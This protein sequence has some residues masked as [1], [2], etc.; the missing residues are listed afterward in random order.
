MSLLDAL[1]RAGVGDVLADETTRAAYSSDASIYRVLPTAVVRPRHTDEIAATLAVCRETGTPL[2]ARGGGTSI[3]GNAIGTG[4]VLDLS[5][6]LGALIDVDPELGTATVQ[7]GTVHATVQRAA[8]AH[9]WRFGP[10]PS[11]H[12]RA[13]VGGMIGNNA[14]G[15]RALAY[16]RMSD[17]IVALTGITG[18]GEEF[19]VASAAHSPRPH[20]SVP[21]EARLADLAAADLETVRTEFGRFGRQASGYAL[22]HLLPERGRDMTRML[23]GSE[24]TLAVVTRATVR[25]V[26]DPPHRRLVVLGFPDFPAAGDAVPAILEL[27]PTACEGI[28]ARIVDVVR[29]RRGPAAVP[30]LPTGSA[31]LFVEISGFDEAEV[32]ERAGR[33]AVPGADR[34]AVD[35]PARAAEL[36]RIREDGA[37]LSSPSPAGLPALAGWEDAAVPPAV[38]GSYLRDFE[39][40][41]VEHRLTGYPY[42]HL[43]DGCLHI[44]LDFPLTGGRGRTAFVEFLDAAAELA[45]GYG[46][47]LSGEH[48]D[49]RARSALLER[50]YSPRAMELMSAVK[51][52]CD[53]GNLLNPG[54][55]V[56]P[57]PLTADL[58]PVAAHPYRRSLALAY[59]EDGGDFSRAVHRCTGVGKC[60]ADNGA[61]NGVMCPSY[62]ATREEQ[63]STRGRARVLQEMLDSTAGQPD[64]RSPAVH[65]ALDLC[66]SCKGCLSDC[67]TG[68]DMASYKAEVLHQSYRRRLRPRSHYALGWLPRWARLASVAPRAANAVLR[69]PPLA[70]ALRW[71]AGVDPRRSLPQFA[72][73]RFGAVFAG[74]RRRPA[75]TPERG[76][77]LLW[78]DTFTE[79]FS[80]EVGVAAVRVLEDAGYEVRIPERTLCC[81]L[82]WI[83]TGQLDAARRILRQTVQA[84]DPVVA[85]GIPIVGLEPSCTA[86]LRHDALELLGEPA[87]A[88]AGAVRTLAEVLT[89]ADYTMPDL[90][91][92]S[93]VAQ[94]HCHQH[95][96][97]GW[98]ADEQ[99][100][101]GAGAQVDRVAGCCGLAGNFGMELGHY[102]TSVAVAEHD[103]LPAVRA[104]AADA[105][106]LADGFSCR[107]QLADLAD[108]I[109]PSGHPVRHLA[110]LIDDALN[111]RP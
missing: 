13:T 27:S 9:G 45:L 88:V 17:N 78:V 39:Q 7:P 64:W 83:S 106:V 107:T 23:V 108:R 29:R 97:M 24:G 63:D 14:C 55:V 21:I 41:L 48:G 109:A 33:V 69:V 94:P 103:L 52:I 68:V 22:E 36:W 67:P 10:D 62:L 12:T 1:R 60:R 93:V 81:G 90:T 51:Q 99:L 28:D 74:R 61:T 2:V 50:M 18:T 26:R 56:D 32:I 44:R 72:V 100:L 102:E 89:E 80:P 6:H 105:T 70:R 92:T 38:I 66:L 43:G 71:T 87:T 91:G 5:R 98:G 20:P 31:W 76:P 54:I 3:A 19:S 75:R 59:V 82:S 53:P 73:R 104:A 35:D 110:Q 96:V 46:G 47:S 79:H 4:I 86:A 25:L 111:S 77:V 95:A 8:M 65:E 40:L 15:T 101:T 16:G 34:L 84:L 49:G 37:G 30:T 58:R 57:R 42:G 85:Q 11:S